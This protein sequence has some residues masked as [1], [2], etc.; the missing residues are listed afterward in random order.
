MRYRKTIKSRL[1][2]L[3]GVRRWLRVRL[4]T[5]GVDGAA[6]RKSELAITEALAN[7]VQHAYHGEESGVIHISLVVDRS[8]IRLVIRDFA[9]PF[10]PLNS[11]GPEAQPRL[12][13][14][15]GLGMSILRQSMDVVRYEHPPPT[16]TRLTMERRRELLTPGAGEGLL[17]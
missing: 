9:E 1:G 6:I 10:T 7:V 11:G 17:P 12:S 8:L 4:Q 2:E 5:A 14:K 13:S 3:S 16:G 15:G